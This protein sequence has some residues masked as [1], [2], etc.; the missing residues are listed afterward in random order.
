LDSLYRS[1]DVCVLIAVS[2]IIGS[3]KPL[4]PIEEGLVP[5]NWHTKCRDRSA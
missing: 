2:V 5:S 3:E 4:E 1:E